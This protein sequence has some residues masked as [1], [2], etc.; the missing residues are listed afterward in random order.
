MFRIRRFG[1]VRTANVVALLYLVVFAILILP[2]AVFFMATGTTPGQAGALVGGAVAA[3]VFYVVLGWVFTAIACLIYNFVARFAG[4]IEVEVERVGPGGPSAGYPYGGPYGQVTGQAP[5]GSPT[6]P[7]PPGYG[8]DQPPR[9]GLGQPPGY[10]PA[11]PPTS[12]RR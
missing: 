5:W 6:G 9:Y 8:T 3:L 1:V 10:G 4:G 7:Q 11:E 2:F 12:D